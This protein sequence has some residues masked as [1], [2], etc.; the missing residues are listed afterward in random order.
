MI[1]ATIISLTVSTLFH[2]ST[3]ICGLI[4]KRVLCS[5][6][7]AICMSEAFQTD[8]IW[9]AQAYTFPLTL[10]T[11]L[12][13]RNVIA[14][15]SQETQGPLN[16]THPIPTPPLALCILQAH[17]K[18]TEMWP[19]KRETILRDAI[20]PVQLLHSNSANTVLSIQFYFYSFLK[21]PAI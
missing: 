7:K 14:Y 6:Q 10:L 8:W 13:F 19:G 20:Q 3:P 4:N 18:L 9:A 17:F 2:P 16:M 12:G 11:P 21:F 1:P 15:L 5:R